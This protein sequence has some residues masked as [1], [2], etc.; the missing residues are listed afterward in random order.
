MSTTTGNS[1]A[2]CGAS[3]SAQ[4]KFCHACGQP[5][6][7]Q[8]RRG[9]NFL[10]IIGGF[11]VVVVLV[12]IAYSAG[13]RAGQA[14]TAG[15]APPSAGAPGGAMPDL[16]SMS[17]REQAD[18]LFN[19]VMT[20]HQ[21]GNVEEINLFKPMALQAYDVMGPL[22][23]DAHYHVGLI[24][25]ISGS[26]DSAAARADSIEAAVP[27]HLLAIMLRTSVARLAGD[28]PTE[29]QLER[30]FLDNYDAQMASGRQEYLDHQRAIDT[31]KTQAELDLGVASGG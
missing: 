24:H 17:P 19:R 7:T 8:Q 11:V 29:Q 18:R 13:Q 15:G 28:A 12:A 27:N 14:P 16:A 1:C 10:W 22:D 9:P 6:A 31:Y 30:R 2:N 23:P 21:N 25:S 4:A 3:L 20:A 5:A 26:T